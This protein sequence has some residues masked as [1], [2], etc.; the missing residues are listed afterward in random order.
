MQRLILKNTNGK[1]G[2]SQEETVCIQLQ[3]HQ[4]WFESQSLYSASTESCAADGWCELGSS[5]RHFLELL[6][7]SLALRDSLTLLLE[8][9]FCCHQGSHSS[10]QF[11]L[12]PS[13]IISLHRK[14][15]LFLHSPKSLNN[16]NL[17]LK[18]LKESLG[19]QT[20][21]CILWEITL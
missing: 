8:P 17:F 7:H 9:H 16:I 20:E 11:A 12:S 14:H 2:G 4:N 15:T 13:H 18:Y 6:L 19:R 1:A 5:G 21:P 10:V 3:E